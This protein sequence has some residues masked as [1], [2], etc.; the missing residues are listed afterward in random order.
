MKTTMLMSLLVAN[1]AMAN[2]MELPN[3]TKIT[4]RLEQNLSSA[5]A[6]EGQPVQLTVTEDI[7]VDD[8]VVIAQGAPVLGT[9]TQAMPKRRMGRTGKL[10]F[11][12]DR[13]RAV[14]GKFVPLRYTMHKKE[15]GSH[16]GRTGALTAGAAV[17]FWPAAPAFLLMK[18]KDVDIHRGVTFDVFTDQDHKVA[19][20]A[21]PAQML[22]AS[23]QMP[24][25]QGVAP[26]DA[27][28]RTTVN[29]S[30]DVQG[31]EVE[32]DGAFVGSTP[33]TRMLNPGNHK[34]VVRDGARI[35]ER[36]LA[37]QAGES[38]NVKAT[39]LRR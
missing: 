12:I 5:T 35:W 17:V 38:I 16:A 7:R 25:A 11:S 10:D 8:V 1:L 31:A 15:G 14:D 23:N 30:S 29:I 3:G 26:V 37:V 24:Q 2:V 13:V 9:I 32:I 39:L 19:V 28:A 4:C 34:V 21:K 18:G 6:E 20:L 33:T 22:M 36:I 27:A